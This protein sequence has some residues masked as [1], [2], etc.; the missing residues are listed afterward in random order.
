MITHRNWLI[1]IL[2]QR[3]S[4]RT[5][6]HHWR[7]DCS[8]SRNCRN[9]IGWCSWNDFLHLLIAFMVK[10]FWRTYYTIISHKQKNFRAISTLEI[11]CRFRRTEECHAVVK[12]IRR[13]IS[14]H[15]CRR[16]TYWRG[17]NFQWPRE[18]LQA[19]NIIN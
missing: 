16:N 3:L 7:T 19:T 17:L 9:L 5:R 14:I 6:I 15:H 1:R 2:I 18:R 12:H 13:T 10:I 11:G 8:C 4:W